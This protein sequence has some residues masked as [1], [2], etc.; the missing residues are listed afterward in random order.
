MQAAQVSHQCPADHDVVEV[1]DHEIGIGDVHV[2]T[3]G[4]EEQAGEAADGEQTD[5]AERVKHGRV[6]MDGTFIES[7]C[8]VENFYGG[9]H[10]DRIA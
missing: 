4:G 2:D 10:R 8:P 7:R 5:E 9:W 6:V 3:Q 1:G